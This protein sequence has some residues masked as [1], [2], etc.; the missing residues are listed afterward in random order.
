MA[1]TIAQQRVQDLQ[2]ILQ[3]P[4]NFLL[5]RSQKLKKKTQKQTN[6]KALDPSAI[7]ARNHTGTFSS[8]L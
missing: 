3:A 1:L 8:T 5:L 6:K 7:T 2:Y 4:N